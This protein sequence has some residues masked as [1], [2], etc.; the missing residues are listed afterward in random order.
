MRYSGNI[1]D[2]GGSGSIGASGSGSTSAATIGR[3]VS[4]RIISTQIGI[5][6]GRFFPSMGRSRT[7]DIAD[8]DPLTR[9]KKKSIGQSIAKFFHF[10]RI[11][12]NVANNT[13]YRNMVSKIQKCGPGIQPP[14]AHDIASPYLDEQVEEIKTWILSCKKQ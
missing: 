8:I 12:S 13:Y 4:A 11:P 6:I 14:T 7:V 5:G 2:A 10:N 1:I 3:T 9:E